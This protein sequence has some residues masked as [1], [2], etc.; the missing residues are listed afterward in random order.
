MRAGRLLAL[1]LHLQRTGGAT[2]GGLAAQL[3]V[4]VRTIYRDV[5]AL[6][7]AGVPVWTEPGPHGGIRLLEGWRTRLDGLTGDEAGALFLAGAPTAAAAL[8][9]GAVLAAAQTKLLATL[10]PELR[11]RAG[12]VAERFHLDA[13]GW[14]SRDEPPVHLATIAA[15]LW[16]DH[17]LR[18]RYARRDRSVVRTVDPLGL[19]CKAGTWYLLAQHRG[20]HR[21]YRVD[22]VTAAERR[23]E[24]F[25][26]PALDLP[27]AW[28]AASAAFDRSMLRA[29]V[30][31]DLSPTGQRLLR[32]H[33]D[34]AAATAA[35]AARSPAAP[36]RPDGWCR[37]TLAVESEEVAAA[38]LLALG[39]HVVVV[40]PRALRVRLAAEAHAIA[41]LNAG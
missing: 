8:G 29:T 14:F 1:L 18:I 38:Q 19:V 17:R 13:P 30:R 39:A 11:G 9:L 4:S 28:A 35:L 36:G 5:A 26:R 31:L 12:R 2:A 20:G 10:P 23:A 32:H 16:D 41:V 33:V 25:A 24:R 7:E 27:A 37:V 6:Q 3:E 40:E 15:A 21:T 34:P 22:R